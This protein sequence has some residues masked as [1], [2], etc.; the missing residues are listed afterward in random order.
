MDRYRK[1]ES[2]I[3]VTTCLS[4]LQFG[5]YFLILVKGP[6]STINQEKEKTKILK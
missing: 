3:D 5:T 6:Y 2:R 4:V 1:E